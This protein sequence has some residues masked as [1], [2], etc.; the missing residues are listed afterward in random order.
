[1]RMSSCVRAERKG[2]IILYRERTCARAQRQI[3]ACDV[4]GP[5]R[6]LLLNDNL[7]PNNGL[8]QQHPCIC[9]WFSNVDTAPKDN[10]LLLHVLS[11]VATHLELENLLLKWPTHMEGKLVLAVQWE[12]RL[13]C[14]PGPGFS[15]PQGCLDSL[16]LGHRG[17]KGKTWKLPVL[18]KPRL[19]TGTGL[20]PP[21]SIGQFSHKPTFDSVAWMTKS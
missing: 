9:S 2:T 14:Q 15:F 21:Y 20:L 5:F 16:Q 7:P 17:P 18:S 4:W 13:G 8:R 6:Y 19:R 10:A 1:M 3:R 11:T 12:L